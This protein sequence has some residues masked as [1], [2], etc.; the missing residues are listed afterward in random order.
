MSR[1]TK[2]ATA[3]ALDKIFYTS[4]FTCMWMTVIVCLFSNLFSNWLQYEVFIES[5]TDTTPGRKVVSLGDFYFECSFL[6]KKF[7]IVCY[8]RLILCDNPECRTPDAIQ[9]SKSNHM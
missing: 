7:S 8:M 5:A 2:E 9:P 6:I 3:I 1:R 4:V